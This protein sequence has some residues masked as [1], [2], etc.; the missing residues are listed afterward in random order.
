M[1]STGI[2]STKNVAAP[3]SGSETLVFKKT[4]LVLFL[5]RDIM[6]GAHIDAAHQIQHIS[7][8][9]HAN[10]KNKISRCDDQEFVPAAEPT[11]T[12]Y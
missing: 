2:G 1:R 6:D 8:L 11:G 9:C 3:G 5:Y 7:P 12:F 10:A 4:N